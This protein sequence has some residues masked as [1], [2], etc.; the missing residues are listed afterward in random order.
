MNRPLLS[1]G[2]ADALLFDLGR[3][4][5][6]ID[7]GK[8]LACW[9]GRAGSEPAHLAKRF[10]RGDAYHR[11]ERG[12]IGDAEYFASLRAAFGIGI[13]DAH[14][15]EGWNAIFAGEIDAVRKS[16]DRL[17]HHSRRRFRLGHRGGRREWLVG[18]HHKHDQSV[19]IAGTA[20]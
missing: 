2:A 11:H 20:A 15:L 13:S 5:L 12:E 3:V 7:F 6:D 9:A 14:F 8:A 18:I 16:P 17:E 4:V 1:P 19:Q 10:V